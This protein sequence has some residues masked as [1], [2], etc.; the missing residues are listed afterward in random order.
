MIEP[1]GQQFRDAVVLLVED[2]VDHAFL[3]RESFED[4]KVRLVLHHVERGDLCMAFLRRE[5]PYT[6]AP[7]PDLILLDLDMPRMDG[8]EVLKAINEDYALR[9]LPVIVM[10]T[11]AEAV[12]VQRMYDLRCSSYIAKPNDF[13]RLSQVIRQ[14]VHYWLNVVTLPA[15]GDSL[16]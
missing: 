12:D 9:S 11:S 14:M 10:T 7:R 3:I 13:E 6:D 8:Y 15:R 1:L 2:N 16:R 5:G 4:A